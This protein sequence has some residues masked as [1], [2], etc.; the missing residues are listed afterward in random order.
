MQI[1]IY[2]KYKTGFETVG[3][4]SSNG[5]MIIVNPL[6]YVA[7]SVAKF[8]TRTNEE[9]VDG[10]GISN[11]RKREDIREEQNLNGFLSIQTREATSFKNPNHKYIKLND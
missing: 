5:S 6:V 2:L 11:V 1:C 8:I 9:K 4:L 3:V 10:S 7:T